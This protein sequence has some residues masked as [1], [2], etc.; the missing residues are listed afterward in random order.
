MKSENGVDTHALR[1]LAPVALCFYSVLYA[2]TVLST[3][4]Y[5]VSQK[6]FPVFWMSLRGVK[7][8]SNLYPAKI[9]G[10]S[11]RITYGFIVIVR[12]KFRIL[13]KS[14]TRQNMS[15]RA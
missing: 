3:G 10:C 14:I 7:Q 5:S 6:D 4:I 15:L 11:D 13:N 9:Q 2:S 1:A 12:I 8:R